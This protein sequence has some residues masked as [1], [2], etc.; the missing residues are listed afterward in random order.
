MT[1]IN[2]EMTPCAHFRNQDMVT[3]L[4]NV[5]SERPKTTAPKPRQTIFYLIDHNKKNGSMYILP[6]CIAGIQQK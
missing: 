3:I 4:F 2:K 1:E 6:E 5:L